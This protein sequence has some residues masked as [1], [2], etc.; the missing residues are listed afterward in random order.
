[1]SGSVD[2]VRTLLDARASVSAG[3]LRFARLALNHVDAQV[4]L[5]LAAKC[6]LADFPTAA[7]FS[8]SGRRTCKADSEAAAVRLLDAFQVLERTF[9]ATA[10]TSCRTRSC[11]P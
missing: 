8:F 10:T 9:Q 3:N 11:T 6:T 1:M 5:L 2:V 4:A 7:Q